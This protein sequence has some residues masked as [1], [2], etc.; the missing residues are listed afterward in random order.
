MIFF[1][2]CSKNICKIAATF[3]FVV[4]FLPYLTKNCLFYVILVLKEEQLH[5][6]KIL[7]KKRS[8]HDTVTYSKSDLFVFPHPHHCL[9]IT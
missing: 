2:A 6:N 9:E 7:L 8:T 1:N 3:S 4:N 5:K